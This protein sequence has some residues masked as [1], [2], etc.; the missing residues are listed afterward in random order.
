MAHQPK[1]ANIM[2][3]SK[4]IDGR[5][6]FQY[7]TNNQNVII[8]LRKDFGYYTVF[9]DFIAVRRELT[10]CQAHELL[11]CLQAKKK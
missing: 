5:K 2:S 11:T 1:K 4:L 7:Y 9:I 8:S 6:E 10:K 3:T